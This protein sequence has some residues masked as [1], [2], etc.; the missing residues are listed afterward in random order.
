MK[1]NEKKHSSKTQRFML[2]F[3][4]KTCSVKGLSCIFMEGFALFWKKISNKAAAEF[5][6]GMKLFLPFFLNALL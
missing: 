3:R 5:H 2:L 6:F 4:Q 1:L